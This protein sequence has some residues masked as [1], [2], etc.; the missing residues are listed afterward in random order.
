MERIPNQEDKERKPKV[1][2][3]SK[4]SRYTYL[5]DG[6]TQRLKAT[7]NETFEPMDMLLF[8]P[9]LSEIPDSIKEHY[10]RIF[11]PHLTEDDF[12]SICLAYKLVVPVFR[13]G[14]ELKNTSEIIEGKDIFLYFVKNNKLD[15]HI[16]VSPTPIIGYTTYDRRIRTDEEGNEFHQHHLGNA[17]VDIKY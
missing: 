4:G 16:P 12:S 2:I 8:V 11:T 5:D 3:T 7:T 9:P 10:P 17:V 6:R 15:F 14:T 13:D 1:I